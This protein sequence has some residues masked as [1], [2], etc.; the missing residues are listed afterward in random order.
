M[1][2]QV[3]SFRCTLRNKLGKL[4]SS[5]YSQQILGDPEAESGDALRGLIDG[6]KGLK[7]GQKKTIC[8]PAAE[9]YGYYDRR[10]V[11]EVPKKRI[12]G[13]ETL[14]I[15]DQVPGELEDGSPL[16]FRVVD[17]GER[18][19]TLDANHPL[20]GEDLVFDVEATDVREAT[21]ADLKRDLL[22]AQSP[23]PYLH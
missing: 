21:E 11:F 14:Q 18:S 22:H 10:L 12:P 23:G 20:A 16:V 1:K 6:L 9:A 13:S 8:I 15:G 19:V 17:T 2:A 4:I 7:A 5:S 3:I